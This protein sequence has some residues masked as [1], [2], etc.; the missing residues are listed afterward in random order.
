MKYLGLHI[1]EK[2]NWSSHINVCKSKISSSIYAIKR[3]KNVV[4]KTYLRTLYFTLIHPFLTYGIPLWGATYDTHRKKLL[5]L[6]KRVIRIISRAN[7]NSHT[8]PLFKHLRILKLDDIYKLQVAKIIFKYKQ[9]GLPNPIQSLFVTN[10]DVHNRNTRQ[11]HNLRVQ[12]PRT[13]LATQNISS[14]GPQI[15]NALP[16]DIKLLVSGTIYRFTSHLTDHMLRQYI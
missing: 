3:I 9:N 1:D 14:K 16:P 5:I 10:Y 4:P 15:W 12:K 8:N 11:S 6:Q 7:Y 2:I 13:T